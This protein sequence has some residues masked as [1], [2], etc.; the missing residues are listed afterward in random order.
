MI[1]LDGYDRTPGNPEFLMLASLP[2]GPPNHSDGTNLFS[3][4]CY[5]AISGTPLTPSF[6]PDGSHIAWSDDGGVM[7]E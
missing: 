1:L 6:S 5:V 2:S 7:L 4:Y 3:D